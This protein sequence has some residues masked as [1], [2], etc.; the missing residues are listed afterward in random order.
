MGR[1]CE[2]TYVS[3]GVDLR[4]RYDN[5]H[6]WYFLCKDNKE[7]MHYVNLWQTFTRKSNDTIIKKH[8]NTLT[9]KKIICALSKLKNM[10]CNKCHAESKKRPEGRASNRKKQ[11]GAGL[12]GQTLRSGRFFVHKVCLYIP[13]SG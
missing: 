13:K 10:G 9:D 8:K 3:H 12:V 4:L 6:L 7:V 2:N 1:V 11:M 5:F